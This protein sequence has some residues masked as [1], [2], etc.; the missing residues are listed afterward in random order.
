MERLLN[1]AGIFTWKKLSKSGIGELRR[2]IIANGT[3]LNE[4]DPTTWPEQAELAVAN[5]WEQLEAF[6]KELI[7]GKRIR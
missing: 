5:Q 1:N 3:S 7:N 2:L 4:T 6:Q